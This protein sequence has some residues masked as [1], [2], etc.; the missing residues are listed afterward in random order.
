MKFY[1]ILFG[2]FSVIA[3]VLIVALVLKN[4]SLNEDME[5][6]SGH[7]H[8][9]DRE[10]VDI[11]PAM[12]TGVGDIDAPL[13]LIIFTDP[14]CPAC[15]DL[16][17][18]IQKL[19]LEANKVRVNYR[20]ISSDEISNAA[21]QSLIAAG[22]Q[23]IFEDAKQFYYEPSRDLTIKYISDIQKMLNITQMP[24]M[25]HSRIAED[26]ELF[27]QLELNSIP[28]VFLNGGKLYEVDETILKVVL[29]ID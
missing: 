21:I 23:D 8:P 10:I 28:S 3:A 9:L 14:R 26:N 1:V 7:I 12:E 15:S 17:R 20:F 5:E 25:I 16:E 19:S 13:Q 11:P 24:D 4:Q 27:M 6:L 29:N 18:T 2:T 22:N